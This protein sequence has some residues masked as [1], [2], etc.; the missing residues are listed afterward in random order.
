M[1]AG[2]PLG[3]PT[4]LGSDMNARRKDRKFKLVEIDA[5]DARCGYKRCAPPGIGI[6]FIEGPNAIADFWRNRTGSLVVR[7]S[8]QGY[9]FHFEARRNNGKKISVDDMVEFEEY[10]ADMLEDWITEGVDEVPESC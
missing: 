6:F 3:L 10:V 8:S 2:Q 4:T 7:L 5:F 1:R 9:V